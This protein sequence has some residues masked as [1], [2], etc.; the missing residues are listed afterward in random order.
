MRYLLFT[1]ALLLYAMPVLQDL[2]V[3]HRTDC[4]DSGT[5]ASPSAESP[6]P[7]TVSDSDEESKDGLPFLDEVGFQ[8]QASPFA[9]SDERPLGPAVLDGLLRPPE[10]P[11]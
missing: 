8:P 10:F 3:V 7:L 2:D 5:P 4:I 1:L 11:A 6:Q 9:L